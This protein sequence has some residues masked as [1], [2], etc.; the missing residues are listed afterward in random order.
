MFTHVHVR[1]DSQ[2]PKALRDGKGKGKGKGRGRGKGGTPAEKAG[3]GSKGKCNGNSDGKGKGKG[4]GGTPA[5][6]AQCEASALLTKI[7]AKSVHML[8]MMENIAKKPLAK[9]VYQQ[10]LKVRGDLEK[11]RNQLAKLKSKKN[12]DIKLLK[13][14]TTAGD[15]LVAQATDIVQKARPWSN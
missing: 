13:S 1:P 5:E 12:P 11:K 3:D 9:L 6:V 14:E 7:N 2:Q 15:S 4:K 10:A 8:G